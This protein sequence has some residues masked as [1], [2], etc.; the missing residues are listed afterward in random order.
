MHDQLDTDL[1]ARYEERPRY[2]PTDHPAFDPPSAWVNVWSMYCIENGG[3][4]ITWDDAGWDVVEVTP[5]DAHVEREHTVER[6]RL[7]P[8]D[9]WADPSDPWTD[10]ADDMK[11]VLRSRG[12]EHHLPVSPPFLG[13]VT[14]HYISG[15]TDH[16]TVQRK[17][18]E[19]DEGDIDGYWSHVS[20]YGVDSSDV[21]GVAADALPD[22][23]ITRD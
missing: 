11:R 9:V 2:A 21:Q 1:S 14:L 6:Y 13:R 17:T 20:S 3:T 12:D 19:V 15:L 16:R 4:F 5:P 8:S 18:F 10:F 23:A 22:D 7:R